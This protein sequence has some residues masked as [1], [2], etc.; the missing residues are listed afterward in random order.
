MR[1]MSVTVIRKAQRSAYSL[2]LTSPD[3]EDVCTM[4]L[5]EPDVSYEGQAYCFMDGAEIFAD[6][7]FH[8]KVYAKAIGAHS[9][10]VAHQ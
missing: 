3:P 4:C 10:S 8:A 1:I 5:R 6:A 9:D 7:L 2:I